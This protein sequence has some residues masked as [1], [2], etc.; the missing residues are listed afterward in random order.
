MMS[1]ISRPTYRPQN[2]PKQ[3]IIAVRARTDAAGR[4]R[5]HLAC[6]HCGAGGMAMADFAVE[7]GMSVHD[8]SAFLDRRTVR[9]DV[10]QRI[11]DNVMRVVE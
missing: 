2:K 1:A 3:F 6:G 8:V 11:R 7:A 5:G 9:A 4:H 10:A